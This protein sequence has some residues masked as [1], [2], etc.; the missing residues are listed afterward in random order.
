MA[1][2]HL[3]PN[4]RLTFNMLFREMT[5]D[6]I[7]QVISI[8]H[9]AYPFPWSKSLFEQAVASNKYCG[10][11]EVNNVIIGYGIISFVV[12]EAELLNIS[13]DPIHQGK[14][15][16]EKLLNHLTEYAANAD[17]HEMYLEVRVSNKGAIHLYEK[18][19]FNEIGRRKNYYP[20]SHGR[21]DA[22]LMALP[23]F[24]E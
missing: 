18:T 17:N 23:L 6:D 10:V 5:L 20:S 14:G 8:E 11:V 19:G 13:I 9:K 4:G 15:I 16:G 3:S 7:D 21:E 22:I 1:T 24:K 12:G 2:A